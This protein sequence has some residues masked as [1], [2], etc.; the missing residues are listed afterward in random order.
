MEP[1]PLPSRVKIARKILQFI[2]VPLVALAVIV[3]FS[4]TSQSLWWI[5]II[6]IVGF[7]LALLLSVIGKVSI[8]QRSSNQSNEESK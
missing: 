1:E 8:F 4:T 2:A 3:R 7:G 6:C 5:D